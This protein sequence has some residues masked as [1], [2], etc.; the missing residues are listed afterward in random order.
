V[1]V[2]AHVHH[3]S[4]AR[5]DY[6]WLTPDL[7]ALYRDFNGAQYLAAGGAA[8]RVLVQAA[9]TVAESRF[10]L[11]LAKVDDGVVGV[12]GWVPLDA[13]SELASL[14]TDP[15]L[16]GIRPMMQDI[17]DTDW[18][19]RE[20]HDV[21]LR[22]CADLGLVFELLI[23]PRHLANARRLVE[24]HPTLRFVVCHAAKPPIAAGAFDSWAAGI[25][26]VA[27]APNVACK[28]SGLVTEVG[29][30]WSI[31]QLVPYVRHLLECFGPSRLIWGS[32]WPVVNLAASYERW[33]SASDELLRELNATERAAINCDNALRTYRPRHT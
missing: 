24:R 16:V 29:D 19:L 5:G 33:R 6:E 30:D 28:V 14:A 8:R 13:P 10:L 12:V 25:A 31:D 4:L 15:L 32:D 17:A 3:W 22:M 1:I 18:M 7:G 9:A 23:Q 27:S 20:D 26:A 2:D 21:A 11:G